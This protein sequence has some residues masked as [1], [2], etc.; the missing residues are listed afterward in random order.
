M[1]LEYT[2]KWFSKVGRGVP[3]TEQVDE[4]GEPLFEDAKDADGKP[5]KIRKVGNEQYQAN[6]LEELPINGD[7]GEASPDTFMASIIEATEG[8]LGLAASCFTNGFNKHLRLKAGGL[9][10]Y[11]KAARGIIKLGLPQFKG[12]SVDEV[13]EY[14][15]NADPSK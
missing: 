6:Q 9:D 15:K 8:D 2:Q 13:A 4:S 14:L 5:I 1:A 12:M 3:Q 10:E 7:D 11:Q